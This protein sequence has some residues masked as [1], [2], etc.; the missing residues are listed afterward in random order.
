MNAA[1]A[2]GLSESARLRLAGAAARSARARRRCS[3][4][5]RRGRA[6]VRPA[7]A[8]RA[9][10]PTRPAPRGPATTTR[11]RV[12]AGA[13]RC[14]QRRRDE[15][16]G[17]QA[18][19]AGTV[20]PQPAHVKAR[21]SSLAPWPRACATTCRTRCAWSRPSGSRS[22]DG[23]RLAARLWLPEG[24][25]PRA[26]D[27]RVPAL[28]AERRH[29]GGRPAAD[30]LVRRTRLRLRARRHPRHRQ[31]RR[32]H[33]G[34]VLRAG[35]AGR[36]RGHR[37]AR[38]AA[39]VRR[40]GRHGR[41]LV[42]RLQRPAARSAHAARARRRRQPTTRPTTATPTTC[43]TAAGS[44]SRWTWR[45]GPTACSRGTR[46][47][48]IPRSSAT[49]GARSGASAS[50]G[51]RTSSSSGSAHQLRDDYWRHGSACESYAAIRCPVMAI[52][53]W[54]DGYTDTVMRLLASTS[55]CPCRGLIGP[56]G[57]NDPVHGVPAP[58]RRLARRVRAL[59]R[60]LAQGHRNG[61]DDE[62]MLIAWL[63]DSLPPRARYDERPGRWVAEASWPPAAA[64]EL[65]LHLTAG[66]ELAAEPGRARGAR[67]AAARRRRG[68]DGGAWC[69]D[70]HSDDLPFDQRADDGKLALLRLAAA[71]GPA[72][73]ARARGRR[74]HARER[75]PARAR[76][77]PAVRG[78]AGRRLAARDA[79]AAQPH[80]PRG[81][82]PRRAARA[83][84]AG[85]RVDP[86]RLHR[87]SLRG[88]IAP[89]RRALADLLAARLA[90]ARG[91]HARRR[92][93]REL[94]RAA[95]A[96]R[97][98]RAAC[99]RAVPARGAARL[100]DD[101]ARSP[102]V[103][104]RTITR[105]LGQRAHR[106]CA[107]TG[108]SAARIATTSPAPRSRSRRT[109]STR[110]SR[111]T[112]SRRASSA[113][114]RRRCSAS[115]RRLGRAHR[116][117]HRDDVRR[118]RT[119]S[120]SRSCACSMR[121]E[122]SFAAH[123]VARDPARR[124]LTARCERGGSTSSS[125]GVAPA[126]G[127]LGAELGRAAVASVVRSGTSLRNHES[128]NGMIAIAHA[129]QEHAVQRVG[130]GRAGT[131]RGSAGGSLPA[132]A[133]LSWTPLPSARDDV[134]RQVR[135]LVREPRREDRA[136][137][138]DA[139]GAADRAE[140]GRRR[141]SRRRCSPAAR[142]S[143]RRARAPASRGRCRRRR[144][145]CRRRRARARCRRRAGRAGTCRRRGSPV[146][147]IGKHPVAADAADRAARERSRR[148]A[149]RPSAAACAGPSPWR[150][151]RR[152]AAGRAG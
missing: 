54:T 57:H 114:T 150:W 107:S 125:G 74:S 52:G 39:L 151:R 29:A 71:G 139:E 35:A 138:R 17:E 90:V 47:R 133:G 13:R 83:G 8:R 19:H 79:R 104:A 51:R 123:V 67:G 18:S 43:T 32:D 87:A 81:A 118:R 109:R 148:R 25:G 94:D 76:E 93:G 97:G 46:C 11:G 106:S 5:G 141:R 33:R 12:A 23:T 15:Q 59:L 44:C 126:D 120:S 113:P 31:L 68:L 137:D 6:C 70:G 2:A 88:R 116:D 40:Q 48:P 10:S 143:G 30:G 99:A 34:R 14:G 121:G 134:A 20:R 56:W 75:P 136:E 66:G 60:P 142:R 45:S 63:Q 108:I 65:R 111:T 64:G 50:S 1:S 82:R 130:E 96:R 80:A 122:E 85:R 72:R 53:G 86:A 129:P 131:P 112:R 132:S 7:R 135:E 146:P 84:R 117:A 22:S 147:T 21:P 92:R 24:A 4:S 62:P 78:A 58:G 42:E 69:A 149:G 119:S 95:A 9:R 124:R 101:R 115:C 28:P 144:R 127:L 36:P 128:T 37:V 98:R 103:G 73:A 77:R 61:L 152:R 49:A 110:S 38:R 55:T 3:R 105:E 89:A 100:S 145:A 27:P 16:A 41:H 26:R 140:E 91:R 102:D